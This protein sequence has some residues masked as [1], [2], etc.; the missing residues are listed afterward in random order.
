MGYTLTLAAV[1]R[2]QHMLEELTLSAENNEDRSWKVPD[3]GRAARLLREGMAAAAANADRDETCARFA[4]LREKYI[5]RALAGGI[6]AEARVKTLAHSLVKSLGKLRLAE[7]ELL[8]EAI[9]AAVNHSS[10]DEIHFPNI[11][12]DTF[13]YDSRTNFST[14]CKQNNWYIVN[15]YDDGITITHIDPGDQAWNVEQR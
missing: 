6:K 14:W 11:R 3:S 7:I 15:N 1:R 4:L 5:I 12:I 9:G 8:V 2:V 13:D 10:V